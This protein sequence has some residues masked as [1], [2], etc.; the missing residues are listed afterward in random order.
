MSFNRKLDKNNIFLRF[1]LINKEN[2]LKQNDVKKAK[3]KLILINTNFCS[4]T[5][6]KS[7]ILVA[8]EITF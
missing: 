8:V 4:C 2:K 1:F 3:K 5:S 7:V 6:T